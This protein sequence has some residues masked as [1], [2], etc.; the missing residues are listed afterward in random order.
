MDTGRI[1]GGT[2]SQRQDLKTASNASGRQESK[3]VYEMMRDAKEKAEARRDQFRQSKNTSYGDAPLMA[4][5]KLARARTAGEVTAASGFARR[6]I[7]QL[8]SAMRSD[9][10]NKERIQAAIRQLR[11]AV[12]RAGKKQR[13]LQREKLTEVRRKK[14]LEEKERQKAMRLRQELSRARAVRS[15]R[16]SGYIQEADM[17]NRT[18][19]Q[20]SAARL[21]LRTQLQELS[22]STS[23]VSAAAAAHQYAAAQA[24]FAGAAAEAET[25]GAGLDMLA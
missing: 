9:P 22:A 16:E 3:S 5:A 8:Q 23:G 12:S 15:I 17:D 20:L 24:E 25:A 21:E 6:K 10:D 7:L 19:E 11:K 13:D 1:T 4:Y 14:A 18:Q 2:T